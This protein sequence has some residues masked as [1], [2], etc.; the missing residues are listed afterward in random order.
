MQPANKISM[1]YPIIDLWVPDIPGQA[2]PGNKDKPVHAP[3]SR[4]AGDVLAAAASGGPPASEGSRLPERIALL[5]AYRD[6]FPQDLPMHACVQS[7]VEQLRRIS[8]QPFGTA[9]GPAVFSGALKSAFADAAK[10]FC[11]LQ[12]HS[13]VI[14][15]VSGLSE[16]SHKRLIR[17]S[18]EE[19]EIR[20]KLNEATEAVRAAWKVS[21]E[22]M[23]RASTV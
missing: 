4:I 18:E 8:Q 2:S 10:V 16:D 23:R 3:P 13:Q 19:A 22:E 15:Q 21:L 9:A 17:L 1:I 7:I 5:E 11:E 14:T 12:Q 6:L 20:R